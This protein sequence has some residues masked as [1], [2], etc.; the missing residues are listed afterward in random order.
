MSFVFVVDQQRKPLDPVPPGR[1]RYLLTA[2]YA[3]VLRRYPFTLI[4]REAKPDANPQPLRLK[5][6]P[7]SKTTGVALLNEATGQV[8]WAA[9]LTHRGQQVKEHL[10]QRRSCRR[11][12]RQRHTRYRAPRFDNRTRK[13]G[14]LPPSL[15][16]RLDNILTWVA[17]LQQYTPV[18]AISQE[19][20]KFDLQVLENPAIMGIAYQQGTLAGYE[21]REYLL[22]KWHRHC[23]YCGAT[24]QP[25]EVDHII[26]RGRP[27]TS[28]RIGNL[29][30]ACHVCNQA[31]GNQTAAEF[32]Y[33]QVQ[34]QAAKPLKDAAAVNA[35]RWAL[36]ARLQA[37]GFPVE[38][39]TG[40]RTK[41]NRTQR[42]L[43][44]THW[45]DAACVGASTPAILAV[46]QVIPVLITAVGRQRRQM[47]L[48]DKYGFPRTTAKG[49][50][51]IQGYQTGDMVAAVVTSGKRTGRYEGKVAVKAS[52]YFAI[53]T[54]TGTVTDIAAHYCRKLHHSDGYSYQK[55]NRAFPLI[56]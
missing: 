45:L 54:A 4:M 15:V 13:Q 7:G 19:L 1:A 11:S 18:T 23:A 47:C 55:G 43:P 52:G 56:P 44:K 41:W 25:F 10:D 42:E 34:A 6:D 51:V 3:A 36:Y 24:N 31:K 20:V 49:Q 40:G 8:V 5:I 16:S 26:P 2:G 33:P 39:G 14:W 9:E 37:T 38:T 22:E 30:L 28:N 50:R 53:A 12:R 32:G 17:R 29:A 48:V 27:G 46:Q 21:V 35:T